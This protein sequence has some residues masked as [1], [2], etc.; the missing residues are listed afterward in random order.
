MVSLQNRKEGPAEIQSWLFYAVRKSA[1]VAARGGVSQGWEGSPTPPWGSGC[2]SRLGC[3]SLLLWA[4][5]RC[6]TEAQCWVEK[7]T[8]WTGCRREDHSWEGAWV[9]V[10]LRKWPPCLLGDKRWKELLLWP[11]KS[12]CFVEDHDFLICNDCSCQLGNLLSSM[13]CAFC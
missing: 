8:S 11:R 4:Q 2:S 6:P 7:S 13:L 3:C 1:F 12:L 5:A 9:R 10:C